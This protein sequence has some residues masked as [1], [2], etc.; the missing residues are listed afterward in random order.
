M[1]IRTQTLFWTTLQLYIYM[2]RFVMFFTAKRMVQVIFLKN[3]FIEIW[4][5]SISLSV[6]YK[7]RADVPLSSAMQGTAASHLVFRA[8]EL[9]RFMVSVIGFLDSSLVSYIPSPK[10]SLMASHSSRLSGIFLFSDS[11][12]ILYDF[13]NISSPLSAGR[14]NK[15]GHEFLYFKL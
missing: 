15:M 4:G 14:T 11:P 8:V 12:N 5:G 13:D 9:G 6:P 3:Q 2:K 10:S 1:V 7:S